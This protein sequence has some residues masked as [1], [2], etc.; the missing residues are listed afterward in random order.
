MRAW[1]DLDG[2]CPY[3]DA[4]WECEHWDRE[5][6]NFQ[7]PDPAWIHLQLTLEDDVTFKNVLLATYQKGISSIYEAFQLTPDE[8]VQLRLLLR[9]CRDRACPTY[10]WQEK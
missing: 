4:D 1:N 5:Q 8:Q 10:S 3:C 9:N 6:A 2:P 7:R